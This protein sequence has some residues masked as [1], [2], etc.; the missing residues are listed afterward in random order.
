MSTR[1]MNR[2]MK[3]AALLA[4]V[5]VASVVSVVGL[6]ASPASALCD[7][8]DEFGYSVY[9]GWG[10]EDSAGAQCG[11]SYENGI[12]S[13]VVGDSV[14]DGSC[15]TAAWRRSQRRDVRSGCPSGQWRSRA[16]IRTGE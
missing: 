15:V 8:G 14:T 5:L 9:P 11:G 10:T 13:G 16:R 1:A 4:L 3:R 6:G 7:Y 2:P 12:Y